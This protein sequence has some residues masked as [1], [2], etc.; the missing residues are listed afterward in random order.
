MTF[1]LYSGHMY[2]Y[3]DVAD[4]Y[5]NFY[6]VSPELIAEDKYLAALIATNLSGKLLDIGSGTGWLLDNIVIDSE[7]Y[8][9]VDP[10]KRMVEVAR[11]KHPMYEVIHGTVFN[12]VE[13]Y[14]TVVAVF[15]VFSYLLIDEVKK[16]G[17]V[18]TPDAKCFFMS[19]V[20]GY[21]SKIMMSQG[22]SP[23]RFD[24]Q[25]YEKKA[26][27][28]ESMFKGVRRETL[29]DKYLILTNFT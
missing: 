18:I 6:G 8:T 23:I 17:E 16:I 22:V 25:E 9:G 3:D 29:F 11:D 1:L 5:D 15:G 19:Y 12:A 7:N 20:P 28:V 26:E 2:S 10:S 21:Q 27:I 4:G 24:G 13:K 14:S